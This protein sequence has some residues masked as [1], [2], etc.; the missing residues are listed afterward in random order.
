MLKKVLFLSCLLASC[1]KKE[2]ATWYVTNGNETEDKSYCIELDLDTRNG[3]PSK[4]I[5][6][7]YRDRQTNLELKTYSDS[8]EYYLATF[9]ANGQKHGIT[10]S[11]SLARCN[12]NLTQ[13]LNFIHTFDQPDNKP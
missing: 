7:I 13:S 8:T 9:V 6:M 5:N 4:A 3:D 10:F 1:A 11:S 2:T 12:E